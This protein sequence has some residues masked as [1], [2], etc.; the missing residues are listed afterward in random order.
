MIC[1][2]LNTDNQVNCNKQFCSAEN[3]TGSFC[4]K[5]INCLSN[6]TDELW[7]ILISFKYYYQR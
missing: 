7:Q 5:I 1:I 6:L 2:S 3:S 4:E